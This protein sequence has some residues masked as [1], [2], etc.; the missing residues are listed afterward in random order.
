MAG[1]CSTDTGIGMAAPSKGGEKLI[2]NSLGTCERWER[3]IVPK[4]ENIY[5]YFK[6]FSDSMVNSFGICISAF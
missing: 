6:L 3:S 1:S 4:V 2:Y 5:Y